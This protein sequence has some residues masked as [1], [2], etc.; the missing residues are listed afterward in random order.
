MLIESQPEL[1]SRREHH[2]LGQLFQLLRHARQNL[3]AH[4]WP[5]GIAVQL[6]HRRLAYP[7]SG[8]RCLLQRGAQHRST[9]RLGREHH[10]LDGRTDP[11]QLSFEPAQGLVEDTQRFVQS[12]DRGPNRRRGAKI[13]DIDGHA[14]FDPV[15][16]AN[17]LLDGHRI[18][19]QVE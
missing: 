4:L 14:T 11:G 19:R 13:D 1:L 5:E 7:V 2:V 18:P 6:V 3:L 10:L 15:E 8:P 16:P 17:A 12:D 9:G